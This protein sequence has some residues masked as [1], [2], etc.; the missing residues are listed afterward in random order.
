MITFVLPTRNRPRRLLDTLAKL[1]RLDVPNSEVIVIDNASDERA[2]LPR[3]LESAAPVREI[4]LA[5]NEGAAA[6]N[7]G[8][9]AANPR[10]EWIVMLDD[11]SYPLDRGFV[12]A[13]AA[14]PPRVAAVSADITLARKVGREHV[15]ESGGLPEVFIGC[16]VAIRRRAFLEVGGYD[17]AFQYYVEEYDL[18]ARLLM[19]GYEVR[20]EPTFRVRHAKDA[21][22]RNMD[23]ILE[24]LVR[25]NCWIA[26]RYA[27]EGERLEEIRETRRRYRAIAAKELAMEG[28]GRGLAEAR[29]TIR[30]QARTPMDDATWARFTGLAAARDAMK[31]AHAR[32]AFN[33]AM[34]VDEGKNAW[35]VRQALEELGVRIVGY[36]EPAQVEVVATM[37]PG[38]MLDAWTQ[39][40]AMH[41]AAGM[42]LLAPWRITHT[43]TRRLRKAA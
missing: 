29:R 26:E 28:F 13:L 5:T 7:H 19:R 24:R 4:R 21:T 34:L 39:R 41:R 23:L 33:T 40:V 1:S 8:V 11:D 16:G 38:P 22:N 32:R 9:H 17:H 6:R 10:S 3:E 35:A 27:P 20:F 36:G 37:S 25:N 18:A 12:H 15:R 43:A 30:H 31:Q 42:R 14:M 2:F